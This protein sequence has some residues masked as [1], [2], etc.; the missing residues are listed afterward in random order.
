MAHYRVKVKITRWPEGGFLAE[1]PAFQGCWVVSDSVP[2]A[3]LD[4][5]DGIEMYIE[6]RLKRG[7]GL[8]PEV[9]S[10]EGDEVALELELPVGA[11]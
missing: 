10:I 5:E 8:P 11:R 7:E 2:Q 4:I 9:I 3:L 6:S 1:A